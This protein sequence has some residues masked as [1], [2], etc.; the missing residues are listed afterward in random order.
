M[1]DEEGSRLLME[2]FNR[3]PTKQ[4]QK[5]DKDISLEIGA[6]MYKNGY[7]MVF[8]RWYLQAP[9]GED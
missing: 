5:V 4:L 8:N 6:F 1:I 3:M 2:L 9:P 7:R